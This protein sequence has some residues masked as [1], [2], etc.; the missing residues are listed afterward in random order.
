MCRRLSLVFMQLMSEISR[1]FCVA[2][3]VGDLFHIF[4]IDEAFES[5]L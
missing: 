5:E 4:S 1:D 2:R 3:I